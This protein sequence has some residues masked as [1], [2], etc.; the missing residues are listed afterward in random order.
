MMIGIY[1]IENKINGKVYIGQSCNLQSRML[2]HTYPSKYNNSNK[3]SYNF[4]LYKAIRKY[5]IENFSFTIIEQC[6]LN[7]LD[8][9]EIYWIA[10]YNSYYNGYNATLGGKTGSNYEIFPVYKYD[11][12][13]NY[14][15]EYPDIYIAA[16]K[17]NITVASLKQVLSNQSRHKTAGG[18]QWTK[19]KK[20]KIPS[21]FKQI[22]ITCY[23]L[24]GQEFATYSSFQEASLHSND[25]TREIKA[26]CDHKIKSTINYQW[27]YT[28]EIK[29]NKI[30]PSYTRGKG[31]NQ[32]DYNFNLINH[33]PSAQ[34]AQKITGI[35]CSTINE[36]CHIN[37]K[38]KHH[39]AGGYI[40]AYDTTSVE[41]LIQIY[42][43]YEEYVIEQYDL[44]GKYINTY[45]S[46][47]D[48]GEKVFN[49]S[50]KRKGIIACCKNKR[51]NYGG[52]IWKYAKK[53]Q[54]K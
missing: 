22:Q 41:E 31:I 52:Y 47:A 21:K 18:C 15:D 4:P 17:N 1:K 54:K 42:N 39:T 2:E 45:N 7:E 8:E 35:C 29:N 9:R 49:D 16:K 23:S 6:K 25:N 12:Y 30:Q 40:W 33:Y 3:S 34:I 48:A 36:V 32:Y 27:F 24:Q 13:G 43:Q 28:N 14:L 44:N 10:Y 5:G 37:K 53:F 38:R 19:Y 51:V 11:I 50:E 46:G 20:E 26:C